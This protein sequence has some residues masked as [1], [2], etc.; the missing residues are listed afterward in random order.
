MKSSS[1]TRFGTV[2]FLTLIM[3]LALAIGAQ[4]ALASHFSSGSAVVDPAA[5]TEGRGGVAATT[6][7][8]AVDASSQAGTAGRGGASLAVVTVPRAGTEG[9]G[10]V[11]A[12]VPAPLAGEPTVAENGFVS[13]ARGGLPIGP[14]G[15]ERRLAVSSNSSSSSGWLAAGVAAAAIAIVAAFFLWA[16]DRRRAWQQQSSLASYCTYHPADSIC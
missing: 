7:I 4:A 3:L 16:S 1:Q 10:G 14:A 8:V 9:R 13:R 11:A 12:T 6:T 5:G 2:V 15:V